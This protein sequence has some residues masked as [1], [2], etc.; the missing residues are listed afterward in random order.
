MNYRFINILLLFC[1]SCSSNVTID[2]CKI[3][4]ESINQKFKNAK[5][6]CEKLVVLDS[7]CAHNQN[8]SKDLE[9][10][11][12]HIVEKSKI[13]GRYNRTFGTIVYPD[14][15]TFV[16]DLQQWRNHFKCL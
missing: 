5:S 14:S 11:I 12:Y 2:G 4:Q 13:S 6:P 8:S 9:Y 16:K 10:L 1:L 7:M 15:L 3:V